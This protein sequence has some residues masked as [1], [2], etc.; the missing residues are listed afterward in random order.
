MTRHKRHPIKLKSVYQ[1]HR[2]VGVSAAV[3]VILLSVSGIILNHTSEL[4]LNKSYVKNNLLLNHYGISQ[5][6]QLHS[7]SSHNIWISQWQD[8]LYLGEIDLGVSS[9]QL[10]G[11]ALY[12]E[13]I[14][15]GLD[16]GLLLYTP[17]GALIE[18]LTGVEGIPAAISAIGITDT[19][20]LAL[21]SAN[22]IYTADAELSIWLKDPQAI[23]VWNDAQALPK[24]LQQTLLEKFRGKGLNMERVILD[25]HSGRL[26]GTGGVYFMD[27]V[28]LLLIFLASS[29]FWIWTMRLIKEKSREQH[30]REKHKKH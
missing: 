17:E 26:L 13:M 29:G 9:S 4:E 10:I 18:Q 20:E 3:F 1:W 5:P 30:Q 11:M 7:Y 28:A 12:Q 24:N 27:F 16:D 14:I 25:L 19:Q 21:K 22:G 6:E 15:I 8:R 2:Y 23:T